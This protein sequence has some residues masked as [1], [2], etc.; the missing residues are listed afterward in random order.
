[1]H[2][3][4]LGLTLGFLEFDLVI[5]P[6][7]G[8]DFQFHF[9]GCQS[10]FQISPTS[11]ESTT[12]KPMKLQWVQRQQFSLPTLLWHILKQLTTLSKTVFK[13]TFWK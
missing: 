10:D 1:M 3:Y 12:Y 11:M 7:T 9:G 6:G 2:F 5:F 4:I 8:Y 13:S